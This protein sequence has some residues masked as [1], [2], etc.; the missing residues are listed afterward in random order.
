LQ[1]IDYQHGWFQ[2]L[3]PATSQ[4]GWIYEKY[5]LQAIRG[6]G[7]VITALQEPANP[8]TKSG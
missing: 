6:P 1:L 3:D 4:R 8:K 5:Y 7:Q 2:V